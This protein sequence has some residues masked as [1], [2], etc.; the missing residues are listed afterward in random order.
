M[1]VLAAV[2]VLAAVPLLAQTETGQITGTVLDPSGAVVPNARVTLTGVATGVRRTSATNSAG[3]YLFPSLVPGDYTITVEVQGFNSVAKQAT[4]P[5]GG[6]IAVD[7]TLEVGQTT[8]VVT[9]SEQVVQVNTE[10][11]T[12]GINVTSK[13]VLDLPTL[14][15]N[16]YALVAISGNVSEGD[17]SGRGVGY[18]I[19]GLRAA[20]TNVLLDGAANNDEFTAT[21]GQNVPLDAQCCPN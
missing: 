17:P 11:Q 15:R 6:R 19:N 9:V 4:L 10:S 3:I 20:A 21:V 8:T 1:A 5:V 13:Q 16:P 7:F 14:T 2:F 12:L 18:A